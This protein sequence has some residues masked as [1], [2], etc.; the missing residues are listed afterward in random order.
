MLS[1]LIRRNVKE[2][3]SIEMLTKV[4][5]KWCKVAFYDNLARYKSLKEALGGAK[6]II[7][8]YN[9]H[10]KKKNTLNRA[11]HFVL[12]NNAARKVEYFSSS[13]WSVA[14]ELDITRSDPNIFKRLLGNSFIQN[15]MPLE[16]KGDSN[17]CWRFCLARAILADMPL[18]QFQKLFS[19]HVH[20]KN[21]DEI[22]TLM[23]ML[24]VSALG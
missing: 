14:K 16:K 2:P 8:L 9:I 21:A 18:K 10:D 19:N 22:V 15:T 17:D 13:G 5:P 1:Q 11:G 4:A 12:I 3:Y 24:Y 23:T 6:C 20:L 7:V